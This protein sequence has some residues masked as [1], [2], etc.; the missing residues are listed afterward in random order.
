M[1]FTEPFF[2]VAF[3]PIVLAL[4]FA[5]S[6]IWGKQAALIVL[7]VAS[8]IF[9]A[10]W[11]VLS[12]ELM[13]AGTLVNFGVC[14]GL[15]LV[16]TERRAMRLS[17]FWAGQLYNFGTLL[18]FKYLWPGLFPS[19]HSAMIPV[20]ISFY[21]FQQAVLLVDAYSSSPRV[22]DYFAVD[23]EP[24]VGRAFVRFGAF[25][26]FFPQLVVGPITYLTEFG[27]Q[28][29]RARFGRPRR[30]DFEI[31]VTLTAIGLFKKLV[32]ADGLGAIVDPAFAALSAGQ[33]PSAVQAW[34]AALAYFVQLYFDFSG[35]S[36][37]ALG[38]ARLFG[39]RLPINFDSPLRASGIVDFYRRWHITLT[40]VI[41]RFL[42]NPLSLAATRIAAE[43]RLRPLPGRMLGRWLPLMINFEIIALWHGALKVYVVFGLVH[44][45]W[46]VLESEVKG[47]RLWRRFKARYDDRSRQ[48]LGQIVTFLPLMTTFSLFRSDSLRT[49]ATL[50]ASLWAGAGSMVGDLKDN[51]EAY[52]L[53]A[54]A[55]LIVWLVPN[56]YELTSRFAPGLFTWTNRSTTPRL[57]SRLRWRPSIRWA[58]L[59]SALIVA[60]MYFLGRKA[61]FI[62][63]GY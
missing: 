58:L 44:G 16:A 6:R 48:I 2:L 3:L 10:H 23:V 8:V 24:R 47:S 12:L 49:F 15:L 14:W 13:L 45:A 7:F 46:F 37:M 35:Y 54:A 20:G 57:L 17:L 34:A 40:R 31:G 26:C 28:V 18:F 62:Y 42:F 39:L 33:H 56:S 9:Y 1:V 60:S 19:S 41:G 25:H 5:T 38:I 11:G 36:D 63:M 27:P 51:G 61:P 59:V 30:I 55:F 32:L 4:F 22:R 52:P 50:Q 29:L 43:R 21:T 53:I